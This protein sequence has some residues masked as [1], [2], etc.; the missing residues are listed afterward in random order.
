MPNTAWPNG[1]KVAVTLT[2]DFDAETLWLARDPAN[3][4]RPGTLSQGTYG[5]KVGVPKVLEV[6][7][8]EG[9]PATFFVPGW[10]VDNRT[11]V[12]ETI[13]KAGH[14]IANHGYLHKAV[15]PKDPEMEL[16]ELQKG[17]DA[18]KRVT[19]VSPVGYRAPSGETSPNMIRLLTERGFIYDSSMLDDIEP[20]RHFLEDGSP[21]IVELPWHWSMDDAQYLLTSGKAHRPILTNDHILSIWKAE[22]DEAYLSGGYF[23]LVM[24]PQVI[25]RP[26]RIRMLRDFIS[27][28]RRHNSIWFAQS[29][30]VATTWLHVANKASGEPRISPFL[31][32][33]EDGTISQR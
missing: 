14:E 18:I 15:D 21:A 12:V 9:L 16:E 30:D 31:R 27:Y 25:G 3:V 17:I 5:A 23:D 11:R 1:A 7:A 26:S 20:Y 29:R 24:H 2:F 28:I 8:D 4:D 6:L 32:Q 10:V 22:F 19:G 33:S 13:V